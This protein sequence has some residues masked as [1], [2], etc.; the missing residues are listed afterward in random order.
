MKTSYPLVRFTQDDKLHFRYNEKTVEVHD[1]HC[2][3]VRVIK[4]GPSQFFEVSRCSSIDSYT[5]AC[6]WLDNKTN[7]GKLALFNQQNDEPYYEKTIN[8]AEEIKIRFS[9]NSN[10][11]LI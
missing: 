8:K 7:K 4:S 5:L 3:M 6:V 2:S 1:A 11:F 10:K 9:P